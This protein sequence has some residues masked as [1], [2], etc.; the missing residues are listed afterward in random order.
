MALV[1]GALSLSA[2]IDATALVKFTVN[3]FALTVRVKTMF[4]KNGLTVNIK[5]FK[6]RW[7]VGIGI[8]SNCTLIQWQSFPLTDRGENDARITYANMA[9]VVRQ[10]RVVSFE[11]FKRAAYQSEAV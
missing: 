4:R 7:L 2:A 1:K 10:N 5:K 9:E 6:S 8:T 3:L 11:H